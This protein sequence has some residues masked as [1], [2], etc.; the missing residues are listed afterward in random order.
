MADQFY[1]ETQRY[2]LPN[3]VG[4]VAGT[5]RR[6]AG[7]HQQIMDATLR[8]NEDAVRF[9]AEHYRRTAEVIEASIEWPRRPA[10][11]SDSRPPR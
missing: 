3:L 5:R 8:R 1:V 6:E 4:G 9:L 10:R 7:E 2:R 11:K